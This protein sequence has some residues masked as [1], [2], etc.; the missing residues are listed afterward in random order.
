MVSDSTKN[1]K[2]KPRRPFGIPSKQQQKKSNGGTTSL[3]LLG[4]L[5]SR[6]TRLLTDRLEVTLA[7]SLALSFA[8]SVASTGAVAEAAQSHLHVAQEGDLL[9]LGNRVV[10][11]LDAGGAFAEKLLLLLVQQQLDILVGALE[12]ELAGHAQGNALDTGVGANAGHGD[13]LVGVGNDRL[14]DADQDAGHAVV[15]LALLLDDLVGSLA[16]ALGQSIH[17]LLVVGD[18]LLPAVVLETHAS[19]AGEGPNRQLA[20]AMLAD[21]DGVDI[22][23]VDAVVFSELVTES[24]SI[25]RSARANDALHRETGELVGGLGQHVARVR[26]DDQDR[27]GGVL[28]DLGHDAL[29]KAVVCLDK[30]HTSLTGLLINAGGNNNSRGVGAVFIVTNGDLC[31]RIVGGVGK[32]HDLAERAVLVDIDQ[33]DLGSKMAQEKS[34]RGRNTNGAGANDDDLD[35]LGFLLATHS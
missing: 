33:D 3:L 18:L 12:V 25:H 16:G 17:G 34:V 8:S 19:D 5:V 21:D 20:V 15:G 30:I 2:R 28:C 35:A 27:V 22:A 13:E 4:L 26:G 7:L 11:L 1:S 24:G 9:L 32:V 23:R 6:H 10:A 29:E 31:M 14:E